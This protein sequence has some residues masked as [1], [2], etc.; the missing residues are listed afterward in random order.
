MVAIVTPFDVAFEIDTEAHRNNTMQLAGHGSKGFVVAGSTGEGPYLEPGERE[1]LISGSRSAAPDAFIVC[2]I[3]AESVRQALAQIHEA[4]RGGADA[5]LVLTPGTLVRDQTDTISSFYSAVA[6]AAPLP[7]MLYSNPKVT[8]YEL[9]TETINELSTHSNIVGIKDSGGD[10]T[11]IEHLTLAIGR[12]FIVYPGASRALLDSYR[13]GA[14]GA[15]TASANYAFG[16]VSAAAQGNAE[17]QRDLDAV[18]SVVE[19]HG[20]PGSKRAADAACLMAGMPRPPLRPVN[21]AAGVKIDD[22]VAFL[23]QH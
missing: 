17:A 9:P 11:R 18:I 8:G 4:A 20:I 15:I 12:G 1:V 6:E 16:L 23:K 7:V 3:N 19:T 10:P 2:G 14:Y 13:A 22:A 5:V 21:E